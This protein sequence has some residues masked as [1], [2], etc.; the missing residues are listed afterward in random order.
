MAS[1][2]PASDSAALDEVRARR[3]ALGNAADTCEEALARPASSPDWTAGVG[4]AIGELSSA[5]ADHVVEVEDD[6]GLLP[7]LLA[8]E[9]RLAHTIQG[10]YDEHVDISA[11]LEKIDR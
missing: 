9:P 7:Q 3:E 2:D 4:S 11:S 1:Q 10:M 8:D 5:F 6:D